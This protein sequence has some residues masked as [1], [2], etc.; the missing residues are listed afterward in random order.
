MFAELP[1][2]NRDVKHFAEL[3]L[4][5]METNEDV[6]E[7]ISS[8]AYIQGAVLHRLLLCGAY[9]R[10]TLDAYLNWANSQPSKNRGY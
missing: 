7:W 10:G 5:Q 6:K 1:S 4:E 8:K 3:V 2:P 9:R